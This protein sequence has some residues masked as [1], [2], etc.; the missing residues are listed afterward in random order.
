M[1]R[2]GWKTV[3]R[4]CAGIEVVY[5]EDSEDDPGEVIASGHLVDDRPDYIGKSSEC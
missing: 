1:G 2:G 5:R 4:R 3:R